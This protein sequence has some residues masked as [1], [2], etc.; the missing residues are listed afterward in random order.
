MRFRLHQRGLWFLAATSVAVA[1]GAAYATA[2]AMSSADSAIVACQNQTNG[3]LRVVTDATDC[4]T[5]E[6]AIS[7][8]QVGPQGPPGEQG[9]PGPAGSGG[10]P[11]A[12]AHVRADGTIDAARSSQNVTAVTK[13]LVAGSAFPTV[14]DTGFT[15]YCFDLATTAK[16]ISVTVED[17]I[18][19]LNPSPF[20]GVTVSMRNPFVNA[21]VDPSVAADFGCAGGTDA[22]VVITAGTSGAPFYALFN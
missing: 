18:V 2:A 22:A 4:R 15:L 7:W 11:L 5:S 6:T 17:S 20:P 19:P 13:G 21:T 12:F 16:S 3:L 14:P 8:N 1:A 10:G 9:P